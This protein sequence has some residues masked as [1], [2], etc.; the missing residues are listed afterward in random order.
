M[1]VAS[2]ALIFTNHSVQRSS[3][4]VI[5]QLHFEAANHTTPPSQIAE[6]IKLTIATTISPK[7]RNIFIL[8]IVATGDI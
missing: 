8:Y 4:S 5:R 7:C 6:L 1:I 2:A 3:D